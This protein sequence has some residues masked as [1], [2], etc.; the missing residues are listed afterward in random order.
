MV[1]PEILDDIDS[2]PL[3]TSCASTLISNIEDS[4]LDSILTTL[5]C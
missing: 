1:S 4:K 5:L 3:P 2:E